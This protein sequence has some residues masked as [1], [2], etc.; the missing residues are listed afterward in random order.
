MTRP[1]PL[2]QKYP[3]DL[4]SSPALKVEADGMEVYED[5]VLTASFFCRGAAS[6]GSYCSLGYRT[7][8]AESIAKLTKLRIL[9]QQPP[10]RWKEYFFA[11]EKAI[12][13]SDLPCE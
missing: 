13:V 4:A 9:F 3:L 5:S 1:P 2:Y 7:W 12:E 10:N 8:A 6:R 11:L